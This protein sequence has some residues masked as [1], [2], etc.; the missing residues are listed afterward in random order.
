[1]ATP[2]GLE[3]L[4]DQLQL[5]DGI[6]GN[7]LTISSKVLAVGQGDGLTVSADAVALTTPGTCDHETPNSSIGNHT[8]LI[9]NSSNPGAGKEILSTDADGALW[10]ITLRTDT[11]GDRSGSSLLINPTGD[12][13]LDPGGNDVL[14]VTNYEIS[15]G[16]IN[17]KYL[18]IHAAELWVETLVAQDTMAT[19]G[20][21]ILVAPTT[22]LTRDLPAAQVTFYVKHN[23]M[24]SGDRV[25]LESNGKV[26]WISVD[27]NGALQAEGDY[28]YRITRNLDGSGANDWY[29]GDAVLNTGTTGDGYIDIYSVDSIRSGTQYG[30]TIVGNIRTGTTL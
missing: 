22:T 30:P 13:S 12:I 20:G 26:E 21:R 23:Q 5:A 8:H 14:P 25:Y 3:I 6:A 2:S 10:L 24:A 4:T 17:K 7:G 9:T 18:T 19:I 29:A 1:M 11:I 15:L 28:W 27:D 16:S